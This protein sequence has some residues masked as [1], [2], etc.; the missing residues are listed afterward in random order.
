MRAFTIN[1]VWRFFLFRTRGVF[2]MGFLSAVQTT[3]VT[4]ALH[5]E[6]TKSKAR[7]T[8][9]SLRNKGSHSISDSE[10]KY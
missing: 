5:L 10:Q 6:M 1:A 8:E 3:G 2:S 7:V 9:G 4:L